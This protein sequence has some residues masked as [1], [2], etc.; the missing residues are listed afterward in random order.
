MGWKYYALPLT[1]FNSSRR[2]V[3]IVLTKNGIWTLAN[4]VI[5]DP[6]QAD[7]LP[8]SCT[9]QG[10]TTFDITQAKEKNY[11][12]RHLIDQFLYLAIEVFGCLHKHANVFLHDCANAIWSLKRLEGLHLLTL[13]TFLCQKV[14]I[15]LQK[16]QA[17]LI[18]SWAVA[19]GFKLFNFHPFKTHLPSPESIYCRPSIFDIEIWPTYNK[20]SVLDIERFWHLFWTNLMSCNFS[21]FLIFIPLYIFRIYDVFLKKALHDWFFCT[22][23]HLISI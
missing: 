22:F 7:L 4:I 1:T 3:N 19:I 12:N 2:Q 23:E 17:S 16:I 21:I 13:V 9:I 5:A 14:L 8:R 10:L 18:L 15:A 11:H 20:R 6:T